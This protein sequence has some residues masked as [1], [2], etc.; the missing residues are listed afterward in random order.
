[1]SPKSDLNFFGFVAHRRG[2]TG[3][4]L[5][6]SRR[7][8]LAGHGHLS[9][10]EELEAR[11]L[12]AVDA[13]V[14]SAN[15]A[16][17]GG[18]VT[19]LAGD[20]D[21][22]YAQQ[23]ATQ[24]PSLLYAN[25]ASFLSS[26][27]ISNINSYADVFVTNGVRL[28]TSNIR[29]P[30][31]EKSAVQFVA[32]P[33]DGYPLVADTAAS[34]V[35]QGKTYFV[36]PHGDV[37]NDDDQVRGRF[38]NGVGGVWEFQAA[39]GLSGSWDFLNFPTTKPA[40]PTPADSYLIDF[41]NASGLGSST[42][43]TPVRADLLFRGDETRGF[44]TVLV[45][46]WSTDAIDP[47]NAGAFDP[48]RPPVLE[49]ITYDRDG[50]GGTFYETYGNIPASSPSEASFTLPAR[51]G[52]IGEI[53]PGSLSGT[54]DIAQYGVKFEFTTQSQ[55]VAPASSAVTIPLVF[56]RLDPNGVAT[57]AFA[58]TGQFRTDGTG[59]NNERRV[60]GLVDL[61]SGKVSLFFEND[62]VAA[63][64]AIRSLQEVGPV[65]MRAEFGR[66]QQP[67]SASN[68]T[69]Y[70]GQDFSRSLT[71]DLLAPASTI[72]IE[73]PIIGAKFV[74]L[75]ASNSYLQA[76]V[77]SKAE[78]KIGASQFGIPVTASTASEPFSVAAGGRIL[79]LAGG[80]FSQQ[81]SVGKPILIETSGGDQM[82]NRVSAVRFDA[83]S[84]A[85]L[86]TIITAID[87]VTTS[88]VVYLSETVVAEQVFFNAAVAAV[89]YDIR[90]ADDPNTFAVD[91]SKMFVS[92]TGSLARE[93]PTTGVASTVPFDSLYALVN[94]GD[95]LVEGTIRG[96]NQSFIM[97]SAQE[98]VNGVD[99][100]GPYYFSTTSLVSGGSTGVISGGVVAVTLGNDLPNFY[101]DTQNGGGTAFNVVTLQTDVDNLRV[102]AADRRGNPL[103]VP[104]PYMLTVSEKNDVFVDAVAASSLPVSISAEGR[105][106]YRATLMSAS[107]VSLAAAGDLEVNAPLSTMFGKI[108][109]TGKSLTVSNS[110][111]VLDSFSDDLV[112]DMLLTATGGD[113]KLVGPVSA[114]N[115]VELV[116]Q[117]V[118]T[119]SRIFGDARVIADSLS[120]RADGS[121][122]LRTDVRSVTGDANGDV[123]LEEI[124][125]F[126]VELQSTGKV[127]LTANGRDLDGIETGS[128][129]AALQAVVSGSTSLVL[130]APL[131]SIDVESPTSDNITL[132]DKLAIASR[133]AVSM[134]AAGDVSIR[135]EGGAIDVLDAPVAGWAAWQVRLVSTT[136]LGGVYDKRVPGTFAGTLE[137][138]GNGLLTIDE[139]QP[140]VGD[141][142]LLVGQAGSPESN[143][144]YRV[145]TVGGTTS[146]W[147][148]ARPAEFD[149]T[150]EMSV[151]TRFRATDG[152]TLANTM[153]RVSG[154][155]NTLGTTP[156][157]VSTIPNRYGAF[158][159]RAVSTQRLSGTYD[160]TGGTHAIVSS[161]TQAL[162][163]AEFDGVQLGVGDLV[164]VRSG[165]TSGTFA[166]GVYRVV[167]AGS[168]TDSWRLERVAADD[169]DV[170]GGVAVVDEGT[171]RSRVTG[172]A[173]QV[174]YSSLG[175]SAMII[176][177]VTSEVTTWIGSGDFN[178]TVTFVVSTNAGT[179]DAAGSLGK[180]L[181]VAQENI[182]TDPV[183]AG[184]PQKSSFRFAN[185]LG[186][187][188]RLTQQLPLITKRFTIDA[189]LPRYPLASST[190]T[191]QILID[192]SRITTLRNGN[193]PQASSLIHG[194]EIAG[195]SA[196]STVLS[197]MSMS[198]F[199]RGAA[200]MI[201]GSAEPVSG[202]LVNGMSFGRNAAGLRASNRWG[203]SVKGDVGGFTTLSNN[204][205]LAST[206]A[207]IQIDADVDAKDDGIRLVGNEIGRARFENAV[208]IVVN[209]NK[210][211]IGLSPA[212]NTVNRVTATYVNGASFTLP[213]NFPA[214][215]NL[216]VG[217]AV[218]SS[219][220]TPAAGVAATVTAISEPVNGIV[221]VTIAGAINAS[222]P[223]SFP[224]DFGAVT[225]FVAESDVIA[226]PAG[227]IVD[228]LFVGQTISAATVLPNNVRIME[229]DV[230]AG[231]LKLSAKAIKSGVVAVT[232][233]V[234]LRNRVQDNIRGI[235]LFGGSNIVQSTD[236]SNSVF[237]GIAINGVAEEG[238]QRIGRVG[239]VGA[240]GRSNEKDLLSQTSNAIFGNGREGIVVANGV[241]A[242]QVVI[243][244]NYLGVTAQNIGQV[245]RGGNIVFNG[246]ALTSAAFEINAAFSR[247]RF[248]NSGF[249]RAGQTLTVTQPAHGLV[250]GDLIRV[251]TLPTG[252]TAPNSG[253]TAGF[254]AVSRLDD[255][256]FTITLRTVTATAAS[257]GTLSSIDTALLTVTQTEHGLPSGHMIYASAFTLGTG[258]TGSA[259]SPA[260]FVIRRVDGNTFRISLGTPPVNGSLAS[261]SI[262]IYKYGE[263]VAKLRQSNNLDF[264]GNLH[265][266]LQAVSSS[267]GGA[268]GGV[269][270]P[271]GRPIA[272]PIKR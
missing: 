48:A 51:P 139:L 73:S 237:A 175:E 83:A 210:N 147:K 22:L 200:V 3:R 24:S 133:R 106:N 69:L 10:H 5:S 12:M 228:E 256:R 142:V 199:S 222:S 97:Q 93:L 49:S 39:E 240:G 253:P 152:S 252:M 185:S 110:V 172:N 36:L 65:T 94:T 164:L 203:V 98:G 245:N 163:P 119:K 19:L 86:A 151:N 34:A 161:S 64:T 77:S 99:H 52:A 70:N 221:T 96:A 255:N 271:Q 236:V 158:A 205:V 217:M 183:D 219:R 38:T 216:Y 28:Q 67:T 109:L 197:G 111:R 125:D 15:G 79:T 61:A 129:I 263:S 157:S 127:S 101:D 243:R 23:I 31:F 66:Y 47:A 269:L 251:N 169:F 103:Q 118:A 74:D 239:T 174:R 202:V 124:D 57:G 198:G 258:V 149:T 87:E 33:S 208:G 41:K 229:I 122:S 207:G 173:F 209:G 60:T 194:F 107:D 42:G 177:D 150:G 4:K 90:L 126:A 155:T 71:V 104:F 244:G 178:D 68:F 75:R 18:W 206:T 32:Q 214:L 108:S 168:T 7:R 54:I 265:G 44:D 234:P 159:V 160:T 35:N 235:Q 188:I 100:R 140:R 166:N 46:T 246:L 264:E 59:F 116:Q 193:A 195:A 218:M 50:T 45:I 189:T 82:V 76:P 26:K 8:R 72:S 102:Q 215:G 27:T 141:F 232:L 261:G 233:G 162:A 78:L 148:L 176:D 62:Q 135:S 230:G 37:D 259:P 242:S 231:T 29:I 131:G 272:P 11:R 21:D 270:P 182:A 262:R 120:F 220:I 204:V 30:F 266:V 14:Q 55:F 224:V 154:Y 156:I 105:M 58:L 257:S 241:P 180:M 186:G 92:A 190:A 165:I 267:G 123:S 196:S 80:D 9:R 89:N 132:G 6:K 143:G 13:F 121:V 179:N 167:N 184:K 136:D 248:T 250:N 227:V 225:E 2:A 95:I 134:Q 130:S 192:G 187:E 171:L 88:G 114:V 137:A 226:I 1:M 212:A 112:T 144:V 16:V 249:T 85:T 115:R 43:P 56:R 17:S 128:T 113:I 153:Y 223:A 213:Q 181:R 191:T 63:G 53:V 254:F 268:G 145:L 201:D 138:T 81:L 146:K 84:N 211:R 117:G 238:V 260:V 170:D 91:R 247:V 40:A 25:N 20:G